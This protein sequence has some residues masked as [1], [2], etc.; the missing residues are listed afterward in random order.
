MIKNASVMLEDEKIALLPEVEVFLDIGEIKA[1][2]DEVVLSDQTIAL[3][4][5]M[6]SESEFNISGLVGSKQLT[7]EK[8]KIYH[9][10][11]NMDI[12][13]RALL[14]DITILGIHARW[15]RK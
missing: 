6:K 11:F 2:V 14:R 10:T 12:G 1:N 5:L 8:A 13:E 7:I 4:E 3:L 15:D 9:L